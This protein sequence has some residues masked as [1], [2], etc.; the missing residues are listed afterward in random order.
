MNSTSSENFNI[1]LDINKR[2]QNEL[3]DC[4]TEFDVNNLS[5]I[6]D[7]QSLPNLNL[8][9]LLS[10]SKADF[11]HD[12]YGIMSNMDRSQFPGKLTGIFEPRCG[13]LK[14]E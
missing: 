6:M 13:W 11:A 2:A 5:L 9:K 4:F 10:F 12:I 14:T 1:I 3:S 7:L 8:A